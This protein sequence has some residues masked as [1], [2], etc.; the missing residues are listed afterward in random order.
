MNSKSARSKERRR[1]RLLRKQLPKLLQPRLRPNKLKPLVASLKR[2]IQ[3]RHLMRKRRTLLS[4]PRTE[5]ISSRMSV[6]QVSILT[7]TSLPEPTELMNSVASTTPQSPRTML[8]L[9]RSLSALPVVSWLSEELVPPLSLSTWRV[10]RLRSKSLPSQTSIK[11]NLQP[12][13][14]PCAVVISLVLKVTLVD[15]RLEN[16]LSDQPRSSVSPTACT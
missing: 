12:F 9:K 1:R 16:Y 4:T 5:E 14:P 6:T 7:L 8:S 15:P 2:R 11:E 3:A 10:T 13:T